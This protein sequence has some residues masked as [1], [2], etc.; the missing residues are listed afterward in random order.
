MPTEQRRTLTDPA[1]RQMAR[2]MRDRHWEILELIA[3][4]NPLYICWW[5]KDQ[6]HGRHDPRNLLV[7][8]LITGSELTAWLRAHPDWT[9]VGEWEPERCAVPVWITDAG[10]QALRH[11]EQYDTEPVQGGM[12]EPGWECIPAGPEE[13]PQGDG[14]R[15][16]PR[17]A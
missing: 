8:C 5:D 9:N 17:A 10:R 13:N 2:R 15:A 11:R 3:Q 4:H 14:A 12:V 7:L 6:R 1:A 16:A